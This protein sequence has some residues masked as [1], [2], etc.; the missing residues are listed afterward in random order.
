MMFAYSNIFTTSAITFGSNLVCNATNGYEVTWNMP[1]NDSNKKWN[2]AGFY[3][4]NPQSTLGVGVF[5]FE[6]WG[7]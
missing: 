5:E 2:Y 6:V 3:V 4:P 1:S 7:N